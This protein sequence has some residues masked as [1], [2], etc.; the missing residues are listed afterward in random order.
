M[1]ILENTS[2]Q[3]P[4]RSLCL[5]HVGLGIIS[6]RYTFQGGKGE[7]ETETD[8]LP[9]DYKAD[10]MDGVM[11][12][13]NTQ[14]LETRDVSLDRLKYPLYH[15][16]KGYANDLAMDQSVSSITSSMSMDLAIEAQIERDRSE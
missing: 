7:N 6:R 16:L 15:E 8:A 3:S 9:A 13:L 14:N 2:L 10:L 5:D 4:L 1:Y 12:A 11:A